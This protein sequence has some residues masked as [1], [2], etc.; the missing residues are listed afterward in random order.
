MNL[1][2]SDFGKGIVK[3][4]VEDIDDLWYLSHIIDIGDLVKGKTTRKVKIGEGENAKTVK[5]T[6]FL[7]VEVEKVELGEQLRLNGTVTEGPEE[8]P[9]GSYHTISLSE[10][11]EFTLEKPS[12]LD[13]QKQ[14][15]KEATEKKFSFLICVMDREDALFALSKRRG[16]EIL[17][18]LKGDVS[19]KSEGVVAKGDFYQEIINALQ[20]YNERHNPENIVVAS[21]AFFKE[22]LHRKI[23]EEELKK[24]VILATCSSVS[25]N[26]V[27]EVLKRP[28]LN[29]A[30][31][32]SRSREEKLLVEDLLVEISKEGL[33]AYGFK[34]VKNAVDAGAVSTLLVGD[35]LIRELREKGEY[36]ALDAIM[37]QVDLLK[38][39]VHIIS[40]E[41]EAGKKLKGLGGIGALLRYKLEW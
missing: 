23:S 7:R 1:I 40:S 31:R 12:W 18:R 4:K 8:V 41:H 26:A 6:Y 27:D 17:L 9:K 16:F 33:V 32:K 11:E 38:G 3:L 39:K 28:E 13:Y 29:D 24:K 37:K 2:H 20:S 22:D 34:E 15:L 5:K 14:K 25:E 10:G 35:N 21:P 19:K 30:F 36:E